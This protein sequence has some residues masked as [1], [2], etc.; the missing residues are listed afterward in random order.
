MI[1]AMIGTLD[2][3]QAA[4]VAVVEEIVIIEE[5]L[6][7]D[8]VRTGID[9]RLHVIEFHQTVRRGRVPFRES[10]DADA[11]ATRVGM[12]SGFV[13]LPDEGD[14]IRG[15]AEIA[16]RPVVI[17]PILGRI[18]SQGQDI[19]DSRIGVAA[20]N[21]R[22]VRLRMADA[23]EVWDRWDPGGLLDPEDEVVGEFARAATRPV[24]D[25]DEGGIEGFQLDDGAVQVFSARG[26]LGREELEGERR[27]SPCE[28]VADMH[29]LS[30]WREDAPEC[31]VVGS[32]KPGAVATSY[33]IRSFP[34]RRSLPARY[35][36]NGS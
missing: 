19:A 2:P 31:G 12:G 9:L 18:T 21:V 22:D 28:D 34:S 3:A 7:A 16:I 35:P 24:G 4:A 36:T 32:K 13:E 8:V 25:G 20:E 17:R 15:V 26:G 30:K 6:R 11:E 23:G 29:A 27:M 1:P 10:G 14:Q 5:Q 33:R